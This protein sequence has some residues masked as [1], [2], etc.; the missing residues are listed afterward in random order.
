MCPVLVPIVVDREPP[1]GGF[2]GEAFAVRTVGHTDRVVQFGGVFGKDSC[3]RGMHEATPGNPR[4]RFTSR[5]QVAVRRDCEAASM[6]K[7]PP[8]SMNSAFARG[9]S[10]SRSGQSPW[11][12]RVRLLAT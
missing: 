10:P 7:T 5:S 4:G 9:L 1:L 6:P 11:C 3:T 2:A 12:V 8:M